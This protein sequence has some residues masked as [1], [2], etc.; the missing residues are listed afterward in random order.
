MMDQPPII[1]VGAGRSGTKLLRGMLASHPALVNF[2]REIN[3][4]WRYGNARYMTDELKPEH[5]TPKVR[6]YLLRLFARFAQAHEYKRVI[7]KTCANSLRVD[8]VRAIF[9]KAQLI[10]LIR[11]GRAVAESARRQWLSPQSPGYLLEKARWLPWRDVPYYAFR[12]WRYQLAR[13]TFADGRPASWGPRFTGI[14]EDIRR[15]SLLEV[16]GI[17]WRQCVLVAHH[18]FQRIPVAQGREIFYED[19][20]QHPQEMMADLFDWLGLS[21]HA[22]SKKYIAKIITTDNLTKWR[23]ELT[24]VE[25]AQLLLHIE[26]SLHQFNYQIN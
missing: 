2:P 16:C 7:E 6:H 10:H 21:F 23:N 17:Q 20:I 8:F 9:P 11:D 1:I 26:Q 19:L 25:L 18:A 22:Q 4:G 14:D 24:S 5:V 15:Y 13:L 12:F 3:Y